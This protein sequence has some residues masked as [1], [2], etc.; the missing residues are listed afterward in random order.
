MSCKGRERKVTVKETLNEVSIPYSQRDKI[1]LEP[2]TAGTATVTM[3]E[4]SLMLLDRIAVWIWMICLGWAMQLLPASVP[5][6][7][8]VDRILPQHHTVSAQNALSNFP[9]SRTIQLPVASRTLLNKPRHDRWMIGLNI[10]EMVFSEANHFINQASAFP[11]DSHPIRRGPTRRV[12]D[13]SNTAVGPGALAREVEFHPVLGG[14]GLGRK[15]RCKALTFPA[16]AGILMV[17]F[18]FARCW[19]PR[20]SIYV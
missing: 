7:S 3:I 18:A 5:P 2:N 14:K 1:L 6:H 12:L 11:K 20:Q 19:R 13:T 17:P 15:S 8:A 4:V 16:V 9:Q 10:Q